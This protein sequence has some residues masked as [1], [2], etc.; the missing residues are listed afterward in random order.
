MCVYYHPNVLQYR[1]R[2]SSL[3]VIQ[4]E[5][6]LSSQKNNNTIVESN[7]NGKPVQFSCVPKILC[8]RKRS[9][10]CRLVF[11]TI[12]SISNEFLFWFVF[13]QSLSCF[14]RFVLVFWRIF[15]YFLSEEFFSYILCL[16]RRIPIIRYIFGILYFKIDF[17][18]F[19]NEFSSLPQLKWILGKHLT[20]ATIHVKTEFISSKAFWRWS[21]RHFRFKTNYCKWARF[22]LRL[23]IL[24]HCAD[25]RVNRHRKDECDSTLFNHLLW[26]ALI[27]MSNCEIYDCE[28]KMVDCV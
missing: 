6:L 18:L 7:D 22:S 25:I 14:K 3:I 21:N 8:I 2:S 17:V 5:I 15:P 13:V 24:R 11:L 12:L 1:L 4:A 28:I 19:L 26:W 16:K 9:V 27:F 10:L 23:N 20:V